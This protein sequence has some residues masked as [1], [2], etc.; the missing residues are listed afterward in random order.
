MCLGSVH[1]TSSPL[2]EW[3][4]LYIRLLSYTGFGF[5]LFFNSHPISLS[6]NVRVKVV[7][8]SAGVGSFVGNQIAG[9]AEGATAGVA[10][11]RFLAGVCEHVLLVARLLGQAL[12]ANVA[13][14]WLDAGVTE[15]MRAQRRCLAIGFAACLTLVGV[16]WIV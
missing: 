13:G 2:L 8:A 4:R 10:A 14:E 12:A 15:Q 9:V 5:W 6:A 1:T 11:V 16:V 3:I 7:G